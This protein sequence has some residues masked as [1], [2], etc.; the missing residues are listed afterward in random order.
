MHKSERNGF[1]IEEN[2]EYK[3]FPFVVSLKNQFIDAFELLEEAE[4]FCDE[5]RP[6]HYEQD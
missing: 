4:G 2:G 6:D 5:E 1:L 3:G